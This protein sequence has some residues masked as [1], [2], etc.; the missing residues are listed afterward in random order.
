MSRFLT[1]L[2]IVAALATAS[3]RA[4]TQITV[5]DDEGTTISL[6]RPAK[7]IVSLAPHA[8]EMLFAIGVGERVVGTS[9]FSD[10]PEAAKTVP[11]IGSH[12]G[13]DIERIRTLAADLIVAW[14]SGNA[15]KQIEKLRALG[16]A[17][18]VTDPNDML[19]VAG[20]MERLGILTASDAQAKAAASA[21]RERIVKLRTKYATRAP[22]RMFYQVWDRPLMTV[23]GGQVIS[24][25]M[26]I[27]GAV[28]VFADLPAR[29]PTV[30]V[31]AVLAANPE[32]IATSGRRDDP[33]LLAQRKKWPYF[34]AV[35]K[36]N[37]VVLPP[38]LLNRMG[39]RIVQGA[40]ALCRAVDTAR[41]KGRRLPPL[42]K[43][44]W[45]ASSCAP[46]A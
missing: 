31:E 1:L 10:Y 39:P 34:A 7:R 14:R 18:F 26:R 15:H 3:V 16:I 23:N 9:S 5:E 41:G 25:A 43:A 45:V 24:D 27:C 4:Q 20:A 19:D 6:P 29:V 13:V 46:N 8:T 17:V 42:T 11:R 12:E 37:L 36:D 21:F 44:P 35:Q 38:D 2:A 22:V 30:D 40:E 32:I 28:N 33:S